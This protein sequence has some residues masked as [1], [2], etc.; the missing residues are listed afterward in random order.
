MRKDVIIL[1]AEDDFG[2]FKLVKRNLQRAGIDN[3]IVHLKDGQE[4]LD[5]VFS[6][7]EEPPETNA[8]KAYLL[9]LDIRMPKVD[10]I[11]VLRRIKSDERLKQMPVAMLTT[12]DDPHE[13]RKC[14]ELGCSTYVVKP[15][16][17]SDFCD[18]V[19]KI[20]GFLKHIEVPTLCMN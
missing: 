20:G 19:E 7:I 4:V 18:T 5:Y 1:A 9:F 15:I 10:G 3:Q 2:H 14:H 17:Y 8:N 11:E 13:V 6:M 16:E 12:T